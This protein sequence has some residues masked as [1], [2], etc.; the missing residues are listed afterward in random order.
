[1]KSAK[2][3]L[4]TPAAQAISFSTLTGYNLEQVLEIMDLP[5]EKS[6][7]KAIV[8]RGNLTDISS[9]HTIEVLNRVLGLAGVAWGLDYESEDVTTTAEMEQRTIKDSKTVVEELV[10]RTFI[11]KAIF[12]YKV[13]LNGVETTG[14]I[15]SA[16]SN[17]S[18]KFG[19]SVTG[20]ATA[21][22]SKAASYLNF[23]LSVYKGQRDDKNVGVEIAAAI[24]EER[25]VP[26]DP[27]VSVA[28]N[29]SVRASSSVQTTTRNA[30]APAAPAPVK[31]VAAPTVHAPAQVHAPATA[32]VASVA[33]PAAPAAEI[34]PSPT[35]GTADPAPAA[36]ASAAAVAEVQAPAAV[37][38]PVAPPAPK[39]AWRDSRLYR[40]DGPFANM[41][42]A[43]KAAGIH[44]YGV[45]APTY[46]YW[47]ANQT[48]SP[49]DKKI[50]MECLAILAAEHPADFPAEWM[51]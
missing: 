24:A 5:L 6:A 2:T 3:K 19:Y 51:Q 32:P 1:M 42:H 46:I 29:V 37:A 21:C 40:S 22:I 9:A 7:Y 38:T 35:M 48:V 15:V 33:V 17:D 11:K 16:G 27:L 23:Q 31:A 10:Y 43:G 13:L 44:T 8:G 34:H 18:I 30:A 39:K 45:V 41:I 47:C 28:S 20:A 12:W 49:E 14:H 50:A 4:P 36:P 26:S 25:N